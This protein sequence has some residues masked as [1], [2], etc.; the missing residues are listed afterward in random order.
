M[1]NAVKKQITKHWVSEG[2]II[3]ACSIVA[4]LLTFVYEAGFARF[5]RIPLE[6]ITLNL[7][8]IFVVAGALL[9]VVIFLF[10]LTE[11]IFTILNRGDNPIYR[12]VVRLI[13]VFLLFAALLFLYGVQWREWIWIA[14]VMIMLAF[15]EF[16]FPLITQRH[17]IHYR[18]KLEAQE[19]VERQ[20]ETP[21]DRAIW[22]MGST[23]II[24][25]LCL[26]LGLSISYHAGHAAAL[27]QDEFLVATTSPEMVVL[28][29]YGDKLIC[30][31]FERATKEV[32]RSFIVLKVAEDPKLML[33]LEKVGPL[34]LKE[35]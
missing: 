9:V 28:R 32:Q 25:I 14:V 24:I 11:L 20:V 8:S 33:R 1:V 7:T 13:P 2:L 26:W 22:R 35:Q 4:Y 12:G 17:K 30:A 34:R 16:G 15:L 27:K 18:D 19:E 29:I 21:I 6:F 23:A 3:A 10:L 31:P 5:F